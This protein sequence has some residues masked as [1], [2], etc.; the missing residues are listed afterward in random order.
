MLLSEKLTERVIALAIEVHRQTGPGLLE[1]VYEG[2][3]C[4]EL[5]RSGI[6]F[7]RQVGISSDLQGPAA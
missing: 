2:C 7:R 6:D 5:E 4:Y 3:L 1:W